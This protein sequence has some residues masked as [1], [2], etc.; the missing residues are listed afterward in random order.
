M[1]ARS[2][3]APTVLYLDIG[4]EWRGGQRQI[5]WMGEGLRRYGGRP[6]FALRPPAPLAARARE[7]GIEVVPIDPTFAEW[8]P[9][10][11]LRLRRLIRR[12]RV[13]ILHPQSGHT[14]A[15][16]ALAGAGTGA[17]I[18][19]ARRVTFPLRR[20]V[21]TRWK[22]ARADRFIAVCEA[23]VHGLVDAGLDPARIDVVHSGVDLGRDVRPA[24]RDALAALGVP[25]DAPLVIQVGALAPMKDP[26]TFVRAFAAARRA[27]PRLHALLVG[28]GPLRSDVESL[29]RELGIADALHLAGFRADADSLMRAA[30]VVAL[31]SGGAGEGIGGVVIDAIS[32][33]RPVA[34]TAAGGIPEVIEHERTGLL[35]SIGDADALGANIARLLTDRALAERV[36]AA[37]LARARDFDIERTVR[38]T[39]DIYARL[40]ARDGAR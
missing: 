37:G 40:L 20:N 29:A 36:V 39:L 12:E 3:S 9:W 19:F 6:I 15:L 26:L 28:E 2:T 13:R 27:V 30:D 4:T 18:V 34:A 8:G 16:A 11:V 1:I 38:R 25:D 31:S 35:S 23:A 24:S 22:Y 33:G 5:L 14:M 21:G 17:K 10:T 7:R 32:F